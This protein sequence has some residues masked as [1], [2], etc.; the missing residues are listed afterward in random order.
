VKATVGRATS[1]LDFA[2]NGQAEKVGGT[3]QKS[4]KRRQSSAYRV[5]GAAER[6]AELVHAGFTTYQDVWVV[7]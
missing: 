3:L 7:P 2:P 1:H 5:N 4:A 6:G